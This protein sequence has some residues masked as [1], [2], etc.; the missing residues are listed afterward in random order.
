MELKTQAL[1]RFLEAISPPIVKEF[2]RVLAETRDE[3]EQEF[4][5]RLLNAEREAQSAVAKE[6]AGQLDRV[7]AEARESTRREVKEELEEHFKRTLKETTKQ[8]QADWAAERSR[9]EEQLAQLGVFVEAHRQFGD[10]TTQAEILS[11]F[12]KFAESFSNGVAVYVAKGDRLALWKSRGD[13]TFPES[14]TEETSVPD[15]YFKTV[16]VRGKTVAAVYALPPCKADVIDFL[17]SEMER[18]IEVYGLKLKTPVQ[19][20][21]TVKVSGLGVDTDQSEKK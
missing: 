17:E 2:E 20:G 12:T 18:A 7:V 9:L 1:D 8:L 19:K 5:R 4:Q 15:S 21:E 10:A 16:S 11:R 14:I 6:A 3:L 13:G